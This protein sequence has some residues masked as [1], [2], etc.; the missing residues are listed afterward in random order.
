MSEDV[1]SIFASTKRDMLFGGGKH[2]RRSAPLEW[3]LDLP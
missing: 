2:V 1:G 3:G